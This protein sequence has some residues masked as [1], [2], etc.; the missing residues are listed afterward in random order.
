[1]ERKVIALDIGGVCL[2]LQPE[3]CF[4]ALGFT[5]LAE[6]PAALFTAVDRYERGACGEAEFLAAFRRETGSA[7]PDAELTAIWNRILGPEMPGMDELVRELLE[8]EVKIVFLSDT[9]PSHMAFFRARDPLAA[10]V[11]DGVYSYEVGAKKP[12]PAMYAAFER[13]H[14]R[15]ALYIDDREPCIDGGRAAGWPV[16]R[17]TGVEP[18]R[19]CLSALDILGAE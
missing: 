4:G 19:Q 14:G 10:L 17:F 7:R 9:S 15:P 11:P 8:R 6:V 16:H 1:M 13:A 18:L 12:E 2:Q 3:Q 5:T